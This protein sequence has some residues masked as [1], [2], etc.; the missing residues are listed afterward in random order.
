MLAAL[1]KRQRLKRGIRLAAGPSL[2]SSS[3]GIDSVTE[4][5]S[6]DPEAEREDDLSEPEQDLDAEERG[7]RRRD[8]QYSRDSGEQDDLLH[9]GNEEE[10]AATRQAQYLDSI[11][12][13]EAVVAN[14]RIIDTV[15]EQYVVYQNR[16]PG[17]DTGFT[18]NFAGGRIGLRLRV[19]GRQIG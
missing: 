3:S 13:G 15:R 9:S 17:S 4:S 6:P 8:S 16:E 11:T 10:D 5:P 2:S 1:I 18:A 19:N 14:L 7:E 12:S